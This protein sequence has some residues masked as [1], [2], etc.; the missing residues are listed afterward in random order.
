MACLGDV[1]YSATGCRGEIR[2]RVFR[3]STVF[4]PLMMLLACLEWTDITISLDAIPL[5]RVGFGKVMTDLTRRED[6]E[7]AVTSRL[8]I[9]SG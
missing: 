8:P 5:S 6:R 3:S 4:S 9:Y 7:L 2:G 1:S